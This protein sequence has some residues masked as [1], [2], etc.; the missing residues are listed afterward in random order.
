MREDA[1]NAT[2]N[3]AL[4]GL[5]KY[6]DTSAMKPIGKSLIWRVSAAVRLRIGAATL[7]A[8]LYTN[9]KDGKEIE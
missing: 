2:A 3:I 7:D 8:I 1:L 9:W 6:T 5:G 4:D